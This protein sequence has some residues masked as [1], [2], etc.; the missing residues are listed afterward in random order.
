[1][2]RQGMFGGKVRPQDTH[3]AHQHI[4]EECSPAKEI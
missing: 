1:M 2:D 3:S 4:P